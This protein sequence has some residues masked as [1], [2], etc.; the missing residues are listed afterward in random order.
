M[1]KTWYRL[2]DFELFLFQLLFVNFFKRPIVAVLPNKCSDLERDF[3]SIKKM[4]CVIVGSKCKFNFLFQNHTSSLEDHGRQLSKTIQDVASKLS[5]AKASGMLKSMMT[6][7]ASFSGSNMVNSLANNLS[8]RRSSIQ[9]GTIEPD[10]PISGEGAE[11]G[12]EA[13]LL[14]A[15]YDDETLESDMNAASISPSQPNRSSRSW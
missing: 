5:G 13:A 10:G 12:V 3:A 7:T 14:E 9:D 4:H 15:S 2:I 8:P 11:T 1:P 6:S